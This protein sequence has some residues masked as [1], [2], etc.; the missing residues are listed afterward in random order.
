[1][2]NFKLRNEFNHQ[3]VTFSL[4][5]LK[6]SLSAFGLDPEEAV[7]QKKLKCF[8]LNDRS[9]V[10]LD[11]NHDW[12]YQIQ[13]Q[14]HIANKN[15]CLFAV[16]TGDEFPLKVVKVFRDD[17]FW[18]EKML[19]KLKTFYFNCILPELIDPRK[20]RSMPLRKIFL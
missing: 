16:W 3:R 18:Q 5:L 13:G 12:H 6:G 14:L 4:P 10:I 20:A 7:Q 15:L 1:M 17:A 19:P 11:R 8:K 2:S 9:E